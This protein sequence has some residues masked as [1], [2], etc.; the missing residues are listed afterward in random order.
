V[1]L[2]RIAENRFWQLSEIPSILQPSAEDAYNA[3]VKVSARNCEQDFTGLVMPSVPFCWHPAL[4]DYLYWLMPIL[5]DSRNEH[6]CSVSTLP[7]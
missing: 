3:A 2:D 6:A 7:A 1:A 5:F 4:A